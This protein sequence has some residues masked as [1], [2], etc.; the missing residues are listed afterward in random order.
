ME[1]GE[2]L[3]FLNLKY[4]KALIENPFEPGNSKKM[5]FLNYQKKYGLQLK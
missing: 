5:K 1:L 4:L 3:F 2:K